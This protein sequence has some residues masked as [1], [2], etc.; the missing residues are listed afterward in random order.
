MWLLKRTLFGGEVSTLPDD[1]E[2][3]DFIFQTINTHLVDGAR[4]LTMAAKW[5]EK[6]PVYFRSFFMDNWGDNSGCIPKRNE[7]LSMWIDK[8]IND[9]I[10]EKI[11]S[12]LFGNFDQK[13]GKLIVIFRV[14]CYIEAIKKKVS[15]KYAKAE[16]IEADPEFCRLYT[17]ENF[18]KWTQQVVKHTYDSKKLSTL[19]ESGSWDDAGKIGDI[20]DA[21][22]G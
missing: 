18:I 12:I 4:M 14:D 3:K 15:L 6:N 19:Y 17:K 11:Y 8:T 22:V 5:L 1:K 21:I 13:V 16:V 2:T 10:T 9:K 7:I 20:W